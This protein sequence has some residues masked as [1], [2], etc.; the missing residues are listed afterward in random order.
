MFAIKSKMLRRIAKLIQ[1]NENV[2]NPKTFCLFAVNFSPTQK[3]IAGY[4][5]DLMVSSGKSVNKNILAE[6]EEHKFCFK[7]Q[8]CLK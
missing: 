5:H 7:K 6:L 1:V 8:L 3:L 2:I 4:F